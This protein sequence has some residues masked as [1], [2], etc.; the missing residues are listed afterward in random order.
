MEGWK[1]DRME[2]LKDGRMKD[3]LDKLKFFLKLLNITSK[4]FVVVTITFLCGN[5]CKKNYTWNVYF[6]G[7]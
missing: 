6:V 3:I 1:D 5:V 2:G 4:F 7:I